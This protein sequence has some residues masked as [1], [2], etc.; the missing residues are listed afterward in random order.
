MSQV[1]RLPKNSDPKQRWGRSLLYSARQDSG[2]VLCF[3]DRGK[4]VLLHSRRTEP[5]NAS[6]RQWSI[7]FPGRLKSSCTRFQYGHASTA[8]E[9]NSVPLSTVIRCGSPGAAR[10]CVAGAAACAAAAALPGS[11]AGT[12]ACDSRPRPPGGAGCGGGDSRSSR[13]RPQARA[14][15]RR[16]A[17]W[18]SRRLLYAMNDRP[19]PV[20]RHAQRVETRKASHTHVTQARRCVGVKVFFG[21]TR[22]GST[23]RA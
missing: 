17:S 1:G 20:A 10:R 9:V 22:A 13:E 12:R 14:T 3:G 23:C 6:I 4:P 16:R 18:G 7:G 8:R 15:G 21:A 11:T 5:L 2:N 19:T